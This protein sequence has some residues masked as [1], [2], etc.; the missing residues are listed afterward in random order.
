[1]RLLVSTVAFGGLGSALAKI[2]KSFTPTPGYNCG[3]GGVSGENPPWLVSIGFTSDASCSCS[4]VIIAPSWVLTTA[5]CGCGCRRDCDFGHRNFIGNIR[6]NTP[7]KVLDLLIHQGYNYPQNDIAL[8]QIGFSGK[9]SSVSPI[10]LPE[11]ELCLTS[12]HYLRIHDP[13]QRYLPD[14]SKTACHT[15]K[16]QLCARDYEN[17][18]SRITSEHICISRCRQSVSPGAGLS[19]DIDESATLY[20]LSSIGN[21]SQRDHVFTRISSHLEWIY[22]N[23]LEVSDSVITDTRFGITCEEYYE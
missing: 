19:V 3:I 8:L 17:N 5:Y 20:G 6:I 11:A 10:C 15:S 23:T 16:Q 1:M 12:R 2:S 18:G 21:S 14:V 22:D 4:G 7:L 13:S 9:L